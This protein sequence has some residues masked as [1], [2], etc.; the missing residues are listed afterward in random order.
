MKRDRHINLQKEIIAAVDRNLSNQMQWLLVYIPIG[1]GKSKAVVQTAAHLCITRGYGCA[2]LVRQQALKEQYAHMIGELDIPEGYLNVG[3]ERDLL[4]R[5]TYDVLFVDDCQALSASAGELIEQSSRPCIGFSATPIQ[6]PV[7]P[8]FDANVIY[9]AP[10]TLAY[11]HEGFIIEQF[12]VPLLRQLGFLCIE[13][14][15]V[16]AHGHAASQPDICAT[17]DDE[18]YCLEVKA[19]RSPHN[20]SSAIKGALQQIN[21]YRTMWDGEAR[22]AH[23][24]CIFLCEIDE[25]IKENILVAEDIFIWDIKNLL[26]MCQKNEQLTLMLRQITPYSVDSIPA[27]EPLKFNFQLLS[28]LT[29]LVRPLEEVLIDRLLSCKTGKKGQADKEYEHVCADIVQHLFGSD[30]SR[31][32][33]QFTTRGKLFRMDMLCGIKETKALWTFLGHYYKTRFVIFEF[34]NYGKRIDQNLIYITEKYLYTP[35]LRN[36]AFIFSRKGFDENALAASY[37]ILKEH[38]KLIVD[39]QDRN[40][41]KML[42][43]KENGEEPSDYLLDLIE[44]YLMAIDK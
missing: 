42:R 11:F 3:L 27:V 24:G 32:V 35:A 31:C 2:I 17:Y 22:T 16:L 18:R 14:D 33:T 38:G 7:N 29:L 15:T 13:T 19:Y 39:V 9:T 5:T 8:F 28:P 44:T 12:L 30:F 37:G 1:V 34:K 23:F 43:M 36:V 4:Q 20:G 21:R 6:D 40:L 10:M 25:E 26:Y 41:I